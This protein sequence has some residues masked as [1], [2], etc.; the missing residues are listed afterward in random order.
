MVENDKF[1]II[2]TR[3]GMQGAKKKARVNE[4]AIVLANHINRHA[5]DSSFQRLPVVRDSLG[6]S[7]FLS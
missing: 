5:L 2:S 3:Q 6:E 1:I 7:S 4:R